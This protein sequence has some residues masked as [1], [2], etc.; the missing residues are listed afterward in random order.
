MATARFLETVSKLPGMAGEA[1]D[2]LS[3]WTQVHLSGI[4]LPPSRRPKQ[5]DSTEETCGLFS[6]SETYKLWDRNLEDVLHQPGWRKLPTWECLHVQRE[7]QLFLSVYVD[8]MKM[9]GKTERSGPVEN[10]AKRNRS[11][12]S[13]PLC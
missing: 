8:E 4:K 10:S 3:A 9:F 11:G 7:S 1:N 6:L 5:G 2:A 13:D 12:R